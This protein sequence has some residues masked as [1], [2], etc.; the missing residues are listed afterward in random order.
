MNLIHYSSGI[1]NDGERITPGILPSAPAGPPAAFKIVPDNFVKP[2]SPV[3]TLTP[4]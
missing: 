4:E 3:R 1:I 2:P